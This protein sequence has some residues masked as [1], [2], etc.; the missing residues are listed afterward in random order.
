[1]SKTPRAIA[2]SKAWDS[3]SLFVRTRDCLR[4]TGDPENGICISCKRWLP[5]KQLQA[6]HF[7]GGRG[8]AVLFREDLVY[9]QCSF[10]NA[11]PPRGLGGNYVEYTLFM[12]EEGYT[13]DQIAEFSKLRHQTIPYKL[14]DFKEIKVLYD[15]KYKLLI[16]RS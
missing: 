9:S 14:H 12:L 6:G 3:F 16:A 15:E 7:I 8:N 11:K 2:K 5:R 4:F 13:P 1:M 10:C